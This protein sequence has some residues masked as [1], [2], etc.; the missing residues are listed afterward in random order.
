[1]PG[2]NIAM[3]P[4]VRDA[5]PGVPAVLFGDL[6]PR[7][8]EIAQT[9]L[10]SWPGLGWFTPQLP[11]GVLAR[12]RSCAWPPL[13]EGMPATIARLAQAGRWV[14]QEDLIRES[15]ILEALSRA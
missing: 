2:W 4:F 7:G 1:V 9:L 11:A 8:V 10:A 15:A 3:V 12:A 6:D 14:E 5:W 13:P